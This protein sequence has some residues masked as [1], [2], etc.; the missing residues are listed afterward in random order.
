MTL[1]SVIALE[2]G[3]PEIVLT[4]QTMKREHVNKSMT[5]YADHRLWQDVY[6]V[7]TS[8]GMLFIGQHM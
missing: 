6:R 4:T 2:F 1:R 7:P 5:A 3:R 8:V